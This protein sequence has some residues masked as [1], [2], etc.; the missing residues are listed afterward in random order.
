MRFDIETCPEILTDVEWATY[1]KRTA[2]EKKAETTEDINW[3]FQGYIEKASLYPE[4]SKVCCVS[5]KIWDHVSTYSNLDEVELLKTI[6]PIFEKNT[7][8]LWGFNIY[9]FNIPF[10]WK[11]FVINHM[12]PPKPLCIMW[13][14]PREIDNTMVDVIQIW[15]Q[16][17][18]TCSL[19]LLSL[20]L[21]WESPKSDW[22]G[23]N[24]VFAVKAG[25]MEWIENYCKWDVAYTERCYEAMLHPTRV[26]KPQF[27]KQDLEKLS[28]KKVYLTEFQSSN[29]LISEIEKTYEVAQEMKM[30]IADLR[31][32]TET[33]PTETSNTVADGELPF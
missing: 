14:K 9:N 4:F 6:A 2:R 30:D 1:P 24:V 17:S 15:K 11:R 8:K 3:T 27:T 12:L 25:N 20:T 31:A 23:D 32:N 28:Q 19:D 7:R 10:L 22:A 13:I 16:T 33:N 18:F 21:L 29:D 26:Q 5:F